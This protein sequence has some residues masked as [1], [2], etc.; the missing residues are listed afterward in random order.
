MQ[1]GATAAITQLQEIP[2]DIARVGSQIKPHWENGKS[3]VQ[4]VKASRKHL[5]DTAG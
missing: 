3:E 2:G 4:R 5:A 1:V